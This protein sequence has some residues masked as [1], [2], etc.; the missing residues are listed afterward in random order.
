VNKTDNSYSYGTLFDNLQQNDEGDSFA[1]ICD[2]LNVDLNTPGWPDRFGEKISQ[3][4]NNNFSRKIKTLSLFSGAGGLDIGFSDI[5]FQI[6]ESVEVEHKFCETLELNSGIGKTFPHSR[7]RCIDIRNYTPNDIGKI[8]FII[9]GPP[10]QTFSA[11]GRRA[12]GVLGTTDQRG[13]LFREYVR[14]LK[15]IKPKG[16][17]FENV[18]GIIGAQKGKAWNE[19]LKSF[20]EI[21]YRLFYRILDSADYGVPQHRERLII[22][23][24]KEGEFFFPRPT[25][26]PDSV[27]N[28]PF[29]S[30]GYAIDGLNISLEEKTSKISGRYGSL[31][32]EIP[33]GLNYS[34]FTKEMGHPNPI[35]SWRSKF[36]DFMYKADPKMP[37]RTIKAQGGQY[38]GPLH[39]DNR[40]FTY[41]EFK[42]LQTF[43]D[44]YQISGSR[45]IALH[46]IGNSVPPQFAR[47]LALS[48]A[49][50]VFDYKFP[51]KLPLLSNS[52]ELSFKSRKK[53]MTNY[54][55]DIAKQS[56]SVSECHCDNTLINK[57][58][59]ANLLKNFKYVEDAINGKYFVDVN[60]GDELSINCINR[61]NTSKSKFTILIKP[62]KSWTLPTSRIKLSVN[63]ID[64]FDVTF[65]WRTLDRQLMTNHLKADL[66]QLNGYYQ[67]K[68]EINCIISDCHLDKSDI[69][70]PI[71]NGEI[72]GKVVS[73][74]ELADIWNT[75]VHEVTENAVF[76]RKIGYEIRNCKTNPLMK[77]N[78]WL[79]PYKFPTLVPESVQLK[80]SIQ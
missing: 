6:V 67:Y 38:T 62:R 49:S 65:L 78:E 20:S 63:A 56:I 2:F 15:T 72:V 19:I 8:D 71:I 75:N 58:Y 43:P 45:Q 50:Q 79:I 51:F 61:D 48:I 64:W 59:Y 18:Y 40:Y 73:T 13:V 10:C 29:Y 25:H 7:V 1:S 27:N 66:V 35:F 32:S 57:K 11:A 68:S 5:G 17:L 53:C 77:Q 34:F 33:P 41:E 22:V 74:A 42:R 39:W 69:V 4:L 14:I 55:R 60:W 76:L 16:F 46:Q 30:A 3:Y 47:I 80:K 28:Q 9:G 12:A 21:G 23:G 54:Y 52:V 70:A 37:V 26:G 31:I 36:S 44:S 24:L